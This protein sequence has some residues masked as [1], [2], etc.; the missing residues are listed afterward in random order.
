MSKNTEVEKPV[1]EATKRKSKT[2]KTKETI[3]FLST[4]VPLI[5]VL[6]TAFVWLAANFYV[7]TVDIRPSTEYQELSVKVFDQKGEEREFH[8]PHFLLQPGRYHMT[9]TLDSKNA[10]QIDTNIV[11]G[12]TTQIN[13]EEKE[14]EAQA[15]STDT[16]E[17]HKHWWQFWKKSDEKNSDEASTSSKEVK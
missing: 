10:H 17:T 13:V 4:A 12:K 6:G 14:P 11:L 2:A 15:T 3:S 9:I 8:T 16:S 1:S 5:G 7:G